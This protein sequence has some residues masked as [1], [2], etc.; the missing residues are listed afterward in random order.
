[1]S[2]YKKAFE[3]IFEIYYTKNISQVFL[4]ERSLYNRKIITEKKQPVKMIAFLKKTTNL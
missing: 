4:K 3:I 1:M 2:F